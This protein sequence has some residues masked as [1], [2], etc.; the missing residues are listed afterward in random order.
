MATSV[1]GKTHT[2]TILTQPHEGKHD[3][4][5]FLHVDEMNIDGAM[6]L[7]APPCHT[8]SEVEHTGMRKATAPCDQHDNRSQTCCHE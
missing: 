5:M 3:K 6:I 4:D 7:Q 1:P 2:A 8:P